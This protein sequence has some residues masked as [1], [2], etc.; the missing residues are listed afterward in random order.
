MKPGVFF[1]EPGF[2]S[3]GFGGDLL[4]AVHTAP[5]SLFPTSS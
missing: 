2:K 1:L 5:K 3:S 4:K